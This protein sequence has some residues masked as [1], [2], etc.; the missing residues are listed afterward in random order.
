MGELLNE[1]LTYF[2]YVKTYFLNLFLLI[3]LLYQRI[4]RHKYLK[5]YLIFQLN[6]WLSQSF[7]NLLIAYFHTAASLYFKRILK[8]QGKMLFFAWSDK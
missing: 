6:L 3:F 8:N 7:L 1:Q 4:A 5:F 2:F